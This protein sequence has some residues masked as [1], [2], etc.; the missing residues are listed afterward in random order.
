MYYCFYGTCAVARISYCDHSVADKTYYP[1]YITG[2]PWSFTRTAIRHRDGIPGSCVED[3]IAITCCP[4]CYLA[5]ALNHL[6]LVDDAAAVVGRMP[7]PV[8]TVGA[9]ASLPE[10]P[11][12]A[13]GAAKY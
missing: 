10:A 2:I 9:P 11:H 1:S 4:C 3:C 13:T 6:D 5:Q 7:G 12:S 8:V